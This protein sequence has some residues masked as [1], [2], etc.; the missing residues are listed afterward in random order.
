[1]SNSY[2]TGGMEENNFEELEHTADWALHIRAENFV[3]LLSVAA[4]GMLNMMGLSPSVEGCQQRK[5]EI[6][7]IDRE[8]LLVAWLEELLYLIES[9]E[10]GVK[11]MELEVLDD[12]RLIAEIQEIPGVYPEK[13]IKAVTYHELEILETRDGLETTIVFDV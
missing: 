13:E 2:Y 11:V 8:D 5:V 10:M 1:M 7:G 3:D 12:I 4:S 9:N 6:S